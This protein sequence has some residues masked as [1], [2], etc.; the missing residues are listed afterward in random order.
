MT[1]IARSS[2]LLLIVALLVGCSFAEIPNV[3]SYVVEGTVAPIKTWTVAIKPAINGGEHLEPATWACGV[4][5]LS[6][7]AGWN[8]I[9]EWK[10][11][12]ATAIKMTAEDGAVWC[13]VP[14]SASEAR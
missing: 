8:R 3:S 7:C 1:F 12:D 5:L 9:I 6:R 14:V 2:R 4:D 10:C 13:I 11:E